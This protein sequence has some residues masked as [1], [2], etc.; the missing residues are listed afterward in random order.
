[1]GVFAAY[2]N[3]VNWVFVFIFGQIFAILKRVT[4]SWQA[5]FLGP[6]VLRGL[7]CVWYLHYASVDSARSHLERRQRQN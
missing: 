7:N 1:M 2:S 3:T 4:G 6:V 5:L